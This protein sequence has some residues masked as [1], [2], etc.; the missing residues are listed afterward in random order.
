MEIW[1]DPQHITAEN[2]LDQQYYV[3][4]CT[5]CDFTNDVIGFDNLLKARDRLVDH[6]EREGHQGHGYIYCVQ[7][8]CHY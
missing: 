7:R 2:S 5:A 1:L 4:R 8:I 3:V 6:L